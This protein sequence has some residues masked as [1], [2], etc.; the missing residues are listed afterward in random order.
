MATN[1]KIT[2]LF[3]S[4]GYY[5]NVIIAT[6]IEQI[7]LPNIQ[8]N[9]YLILST[10][11]QDLQKN[12]EMINLLNCNFTYIYPLSKK[13]KPVD[14]LAEK[15]QGIIFDEIYA[16]PLTFSTVYF[17]Q[18]SSVRTKYY[19]VQEGLM[20]YVPP[21]HKNRN[22]FAT[23]YLLF[24]ELSIYNPNIISIDHEIFTQNLAKI[25]VQSKEEY[26]G[27]SIIFIAGADKLTKE[28][29]NQL[30][31]YFN[32]FTEQG[33]TIYIKDHP[34]VKVDWEQL[35]NQCMQ[36]SKIKKIPYEVYLVEQIIPIIKPKMILGFKS[37]AVIAGYYFY[38][39]PTFRIWQNTKKLNYK[40]IAMERIMYAV[41]NIED[42]LMQNKYNALD[43]CHHYSFLYMNV[44]KKLIKA[45]TGYMPIKLQIYLKL[46]FKNTSIKSLRD[47]LNILYS[48]IRYKYLP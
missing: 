15:C 11:R 34:R 6:L 8:Y 9:D 46:F 12:L 1:K 27:N 39:I 41:P 21:L 18:Y 33:Y 38:N 3:V 17:K 16:E 47:F 35:I 20:T 36:P 40:Y 25:S 22:I 19:G 7:S 23:Q 5:H 2:R 28:S 30:V 4:T 44:F 43:Y 14:V 42:F 31:E 32:V 29:I 13:Q 26:D 24:P 10:V 37:T 45:E 48:L